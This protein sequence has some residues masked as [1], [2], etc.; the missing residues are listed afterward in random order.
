M[1]PGPATVGGSPWGISGPGSSLE[2]SSFS[3]GARVPASIPGSTLATPVAVGIAK[4]C[5]LFRRVIPVPI[6]QMS[7]RATERAMSL[8][9]GTQWMDPWGVS[10]LPPA[11]DGAQ[12]AP[13]LPVLP[14]AQAQQGAARL[15]HREDG[16]QGPGQARKAASAGRRLWGRGVAQLSSGAPVHCHQESQQRPQGGVWPRGWGRRG[17]GR[18]PGCGSGPQWASPA[19]P[20]GSPECPLL[21]PRPVLHPR[22]SDSRGWA[23]RSSGPS[24]W[25]S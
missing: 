15:V 10:H 12:A 17:V 25:Q 11:P 9:H 18:S 5:P 23:V 13:R 21:T 22:H 14:E 3:H 20:P 7:S 16:L 1:R 24:S 4:R 6:L 2:S 8:W 19:S